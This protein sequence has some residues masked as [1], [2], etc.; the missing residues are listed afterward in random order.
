DAH[1]E[2]R[3]LAGIATG[4]RAAAVRSQA[5]RRER[6]P[7]RVRDRAR[8]RGRQARRGHASESAPATRAARFLLAIRTRRR[9]EIRFAPAVAVDR[10]KGYRCRRWWP[11]ARGVSG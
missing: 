8:G 6:R 1:I 5:G 4:R 7:G 3:L 2:A 9:L 10:G 11:R